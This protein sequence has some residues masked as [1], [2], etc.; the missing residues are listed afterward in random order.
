MINKKLIEKYCLVWLIS[1]K[2]AMDDMKKK[3]KRKKK[4][5]AEIR[6]FYIA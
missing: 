4:N 5:L 3:E 2:N 6:Y 1:R